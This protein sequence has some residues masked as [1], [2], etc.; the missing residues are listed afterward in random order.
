MSSVP[1][2]ST[3][4]SF[5]PVPAIGECTICRGTGWRLQSTSGRT[6]AKRCSCR[7]LRRR[8]ELRDQLK[9][10]S[11]YEHCRLENYSP[12]NLS[13]TRALDAARKVV[14]SYP[15]Y[16]RDLLFAGGAGS[17]KTHL[18]VG[19]AVE[20]MRRFHREVLY[21]DFL[22][23]PDLLAEGPQMRRQDFPAQL[24]R[25]P[26]LILDNF[27]LVDTGDAV[28]QAAER[29]LRARIGRKSTVFTGDHLHY[30]DLFSGKRRRTS[31]KTHS[32]LMAISPSLAWDLIRNLKVFS[33][34]NSD[35]RVKTS[36]GSLPF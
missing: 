3:W 7:E 14:S 15:H 2:R 24:E 31:S 5:P 16:G 25:V 6:E 36:S 23:L 28:L 9:I 8:L 1:I 13:Q 11:G 19:I 20:L 4:K 12:A 33:L 34:G 26:L 17:G 32:F 27:G 29:L 21:F 10:P 22:N 30:R 18:A 35:L